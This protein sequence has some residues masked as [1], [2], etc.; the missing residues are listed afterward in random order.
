MTPAYV[1]NL[2]LK[3]WP[4]NVEA[5]KIDSSTLKMFEMALASFWIE[6]KHGKSWVF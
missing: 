2:D 3:I 6:D 1:A 4:T 5:Q